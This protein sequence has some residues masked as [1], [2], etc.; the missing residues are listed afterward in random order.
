MRVAVIG[1]GP[2]GLVTLK[3]LLQ[4]HLFFPVEAVEA[5]LFEAEEDIGGTFRYR[6]Y[7]DAELVS[8][9]QLTTF[10]DFRIADDQPDFVTT[11]DYCLYLKRYCDQ[12]GLWS[13][14]KLSTKVVRLERSGISHVIHYTELAS[15]T[16][17]V[18]ECDA[19]A[20]CSGLHVTPSIPPIPGIEH[21]PK[22]MH[23]SEFKSRDMFG[24][25]KDVL[26]LGVG[27]TGMDLAHMAVTSQTKTVTLCHRNGW[28]NGPKVILNATYMLFLD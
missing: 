11:E 5:V 22:S 19:V 23:S 12:F 4:A 20:I 13:S 1:A 10:S 7:E 25:D 24:T 9:R 3:Y 26:L 6:S 2:S 28:L 15:A 27:E 8:S 17:R 21:V 14:I 18:W 16:E